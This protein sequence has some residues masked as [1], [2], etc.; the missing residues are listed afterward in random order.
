MASFSFGGLWSK[1]QAQQQQQQEDL[2]SSSKQSL[3]TLLLEYNKT[4]GAPGGSAVNASSSS[5]SSST[6]SETL[7]SQLAQ[8]KLLLYGNSDQPVVDEAK[9]LEIARGAPLRVQQL[10]ENLDKLPFEARKDVALIFNNLVRKT[11]CD[12]VEWVFENFTTIL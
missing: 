1:Q 11:G 3:E 10:I 9:A 12:F 2:I 4:L 5:S 7:T 8:I 6:T